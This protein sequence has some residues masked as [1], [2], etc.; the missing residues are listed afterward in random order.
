MKKS[1][2]FA[3]VVC[4]TFAA[5]APSRMERQIRLSEIKGSTSPEWKQ[6]ILDGHVMLGMSTDHVFAAWGKPLG[7][8]RDGTRELWV[9]ANY[10]YVYF[11]DGI[12]ISRRPE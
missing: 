7:S 9:Y 11:E 2:L 10:R 12:M 1:I 5:C 3:A 4:L 8:Y 6:M